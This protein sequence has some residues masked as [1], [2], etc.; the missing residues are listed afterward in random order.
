LESWEDVK[1]L[2]DEKQFILSA[3]ESLV[4]FLKIESVN[5]NL[6][7]E[8][9]CF[10]AAVARQTCLIAKS[11]DDK[12]MAQAL[13]KSKNK[14][15][16]SRHIG[17][18]V[19]NI[20]LQECLQQ[21]EKS[22]SI[23]DSENNMHLCLLK[24]G[25]LFMEDC[26][27]IDNE[28]KLNVLKQKQDI[29]WKGTTAEV[30]KFSSSNNLDALEKIAQMMEKYLSD[31]EIPATPTSST[32]EAAKLTRRSSVDAK[33]LQDAAKKKREERMKNLRRK[34]SFT[35]QIA[36]SAPAATAA[37]AAP[38]ATN[39]ASN[40][41]WNDPRTFFAANGEEFRAGSNT[42]EDIRGASSA[43]TTASVSHTSTWNEASAPET[44]DWNDSSSKN[45]NEQRTWGNTDPSTSSAPIWGASSSAV[46]ESNKPSSQYDDPAPNYENTTNSW[47]SSPAPRSD[48]PDYSRTHGRSWATDY[49]RVPSSSDDANR[50]WGDDRSH[51]P[52]HK[53]SHQESGWNNTSS[54]NANSW[55]DPSDYPSRAGSVRGGYDSYQQQTSQSSYS[56]LSGGGGGGYVGQQAEEIPYSL[57]SAVKSG[58]V[59]DAGR[60]RA[61]NN[62][63]YPGTAASAAGPA[64][65]NQTS[66]SDGN[67]WDQAQRH[68]APFD[69]SS[70][71]RSGQQS[72][73]DNSNNKK[74]PPTY[75]R[76]YQ[77]QQHGERNNGNIKRARN[78]NS[79]QPAF[80]SQPQVGGAGIGRGRGRTLPAW[81][82]DDNAPQGMNGPEPPATAARQDNN[83][84]PPPPVSGGV[85]DM[86]NQSLQ[87]TGRSRGRTLPAWMVG[88]PPPPPSSAPSYGINDISNALPAGGR[89]RG[90]TLPAWMTK[91]N[92]GPGGQ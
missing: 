28:K 22:S 58:S 83:N 85:Q 37:T 1:N 21:L 23:D 39:N 45:I 59:A 71:G 69:S 75:N 7:L 27:V 50:S 40:S 76:D 47:G 56:S 6:S 14:A 82:T 49:S 62:D 25:L 92:D 32:V 26:F 64:H 61:N 43:Q 48:P 36:A 78:E 70:G 30:L 87:G 68:D 74:R 67:G 31:F 73:Y 63:Y 15:D 3:T 46:T 52:A 91:N 12:V 42:S 80:G 4:N 89:G 2:V 19:S 20:W 10:T 66:D 34:A 84:T 18:Y 51:V 9:K 86:A 53:N 17:N 60:G 8:L 90:R 57:S 38:P 72:S 5:G 16:R 11:K 41:S 29:D 65:D 24:A 35:G 13:F 55:G 54:K 88:A 33:I 44:N 77:K 81:M 79:S